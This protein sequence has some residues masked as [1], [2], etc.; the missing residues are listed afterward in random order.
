MPGV[1]RTIPGRKSQRARAHA[2]ELTGDSQGLTLGFHLLYDKHGPHPPKSMLAHEDLLIRITS[3]G[4]THYSLF[5]EAESVSP[6]VLAVPPSLCPLQPAP[7]S[8]QTVGAAA[9]LLASSCP[10]HPYIQCLIL[11]LLPRSLTEFRNA[12]VLSLNLSWSP[13]PKVASL[14]SR[15]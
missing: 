8:C 10:S 1:S 12:P 15:T 5:I 13:S 14:E 3:L 9:A 4:F 6:G 11:S 7:V 2:P